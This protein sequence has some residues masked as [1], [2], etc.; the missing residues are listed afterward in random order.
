[1][2]SLSFLYAPL[3]FIDK[4]QFHM[5][6][7]LLL[8]KLINIIQV[9]DLTGNEWFPT[10]SLLALS[11]SSSLEELILT[12]CN[13]TDALPYASLAANFGFCSLKVNLFHYYFKK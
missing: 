13:V 4:K 8:E 10:H 9:L 6:V 1:M 12:G 7:Y 5:N 2:I 3:Y 11:K